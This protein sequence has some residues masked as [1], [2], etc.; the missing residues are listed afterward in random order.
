MMIS[1]LVFVPSVQFI[2]RHDVLTLCPQ[3][4]KRWNSYWIFNIYY[5][6]S[7]TDCM[8][9]ICSCVRTWWCHQMETFSTL[10][11]ICAGNSLATGEFPA[12]RP[13]TWSFDVFFD[14]RPNIYGWVNNGEA[15]DLRRHR[16]HYHV[17]V[18]NSAVSLCTFSRFSEFCQFIIKYDTICTCSIFAQCHQFICSHV[19]FPVFT[20][21]LS[22]DSILTAHI[23]YRLLSARVQ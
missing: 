14:L 5:I 3:F 16:A 4:I 23:A 1:H 11:A 6:R 19:V 21:N 7:D 8:F 12:Q 18:M 10:L 2:S 9:S 15:G 20:I 13:V 22:A 17:I